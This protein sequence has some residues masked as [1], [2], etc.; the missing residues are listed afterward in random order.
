MSFAT[1]AVRTAARQALLGSTW[2]GGDVFDTAGFINEIREDRPRF[3]IVVEVDSAQERSVRLAVTLTMLNRFV[4][5]TEDDEGYRVAWLSPPSSKAGE[6]ALDVLEGQVV[7]ALGNA[8]NG[9]GFAL[10]AGAELLGRQMLHGADRGEA[11]RVLF[12]DF[13]LRATGVHSKEW[14]PFIDEVEGSPALREEQAALIALQAATVAAFDW[15]AL[16]LDPGLAFETAYPGSVTPVAA[17]KPKAARK[18]RKARAL[19]EVA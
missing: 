6:A 4:V 12:L 13:N 11:R 18:P 10:N 14:Q 7:R 3:S 19:A 15:S 5:P 16:G 1:F 17:P 8:K 9:W 2:A